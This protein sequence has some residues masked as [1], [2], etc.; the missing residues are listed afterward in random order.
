MT[1]LR[2]CAGVNLVR[3]KWKFDK[4]LKLPKIMGHLEAE[5]FA[6]NPDTCSCSPRNAQT[7][8][9]VLEYGLDVDYDEQMTALQEQVQELEHP[10]ALLRPEHWPRIYELL[11]R[12]REEI[13]RL[14]TSDHPSNRDIA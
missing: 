5:I 6:L 1:D 10:R 13:R 4:A 14:E 9:S 2:C 3:G 11:R 12:V 8:P 7:K